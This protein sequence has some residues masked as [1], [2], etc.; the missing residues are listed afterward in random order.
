[1]NKREF[2]RNMALAGLA[3][4]LSATGLDR[5]NKKYSAYAA[6]ALA[7]EEDYWLSLR[8]Q[9][10]L[11]P[12]YINLENGYYSIMPESTLSAYVEHVK[13]MNMDGS[14]YMRTRMGN[15]KQETR[16][17]MADFLDCPAEEVI[18]TRNTTESIDTVISGTDWK[19]G[20]EIIFALQDYGSVQD[21][22]KQ[23][24][25]RYGTKN[26]IVSIPNI[27]LSDDEIVAL[28]K[29]AMTPK[30][31]LISLSH[32]INITGQIL[33]VKKICGMAHRSGVKVLVDGAHAVGHFEFR[34]RDLDC[35]YYASSLHKW[36]G[37]PLGAGLLYVKKEHIPA[38][39][40]LFGDSNFADNDIRK[41][42]H[43]GTQP[44]HVE[45]AIR[46]AIEFH[47]AIGTRRKEERLRYLQNY[48]TSKV[49]NVK[50]IRLNTP[51]DPAR[52]CGIAN[53]GIIKM[54][55]AETARILFDK[56]RIW[57]VAID[58]INVQGVRVTP[59]VFTTTQE[60]DMLVSALLEISA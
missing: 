24:A 17:L 23:Q 53:A 13:K 55:P 10:M 16:Q 37:A 50:G 25:R 41:L 56:Y 19:K 20:D 47:N 27:P 12:E 9:Y 59:H 26:V 22:F 44:M 40:P 60:L 6:P 38:L 51:S 34:I 54:K 4:P 31:R 52:C 36:M 32:M 57:T 8:Q 33:P 35:D 7:S 3:L 15:D 58:S 18:I 49:R 1:M 29:N 2:I 5:F 43:T 28:Y 11:K 30:T 21:M 48:W 42:N 39:W 45:L 14:Y 46:N